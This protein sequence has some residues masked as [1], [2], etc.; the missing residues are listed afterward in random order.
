MPREIRMAGP[1]SVIRLLSVGF[2]RSCPPKVDDRRLHLGL[3][4][5]RRGRPTVEG[6]VNGIQL[7]APARYKL[8]Y[9]VAIRRAVKSDH[10]PR[11]GVG[12]FV[13]ERKV[14]RGVVD[15][16]VKAEQRATTDAKLLDHFTPPR[17]WAK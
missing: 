3:S 16:A 8:E 1:V 13:S 17:H 12:H 11:P 5:A 2:L 4:Q 9:I 6:V 14:A 10:R 15:H 7:G